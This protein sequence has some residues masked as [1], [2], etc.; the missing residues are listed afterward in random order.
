MPSGQKRRVRRDRLRC[1]C[2]PRA[3]RWSGYSRVRPR[4]LEDIEQPT[5]EAQYKE[6]GYIWDE[7]IVAGGFD[8]ERVETV[9][10]GSQ[11]YRNRPPEDAPDRPIKQ[12]Y[13]QV[14][15]LKPIEVFDPVTK[16]WRNRG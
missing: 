12:L 6:Q 10:M 4:D 13:G 14:V 2:S 5:V 15:H 3:R 8:V 9:Y 1:S 7:A 16:T 11:H